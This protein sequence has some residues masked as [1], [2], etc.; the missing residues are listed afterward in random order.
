V[1][2]DVDIGELLGQ[3]APDALGSLV[4][5]HASYADCE[6][7][8]QE[9]LLAAS[10]QWPHDGIPRQPSGWLVAVASRRLIEALRRDQARQRREHRAM[11]LVPPDHLVVPGP[12]EDYTAAS[13]DTLAELF[14]CCHPA[15]SP[16]SQLALTLRVVAGMTTL[17]IA[18]AFMVPEASMAQRISRAKQRIRDEGR[19]FGLMSGGEASA[20]LRVVLHVLYLMFNEGHT[21][22][23]GPDLQRH[24]LTSEAIRLAR[25][26]H[27]FLPEDGEVLGLLALMLL[28][29]ARRLARTEA[30]GT[31]V[32]LVEQ[33]RTRWDPTAIDE[34]THLVSVALARCPVGP[35]QLQAAIAAVH[36]EA[37]QAEDTDWAQI[38]CI[39][40]LLESIEPSPVVKLSHAVAVAMVDGP[41]AG[42]DK[43]K[44]V[45]P[46]SLAAA[47]Y[48]LDAVRAHML[49]MAGDHEA[50]MVAYQAAARG[51]LS[52]S[53][54]RYL[55]HRAARL[56]N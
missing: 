44:V 10:R 34:G 32:P 11:G 55:D 39:Y 41:Q 5:H 45:D 3:L 37:T 36:A 35:Y 54:Q 33:D 31:L 38:R 46:N 6:D 20:R 16:A 21:S 27:A 52:V 26:L 24:D 2:T 18:R 17:E 48:R 53:E 50:A 15:L 43:L 13:D 19:T 29:D 25:V 23:T 47:R 4:R 14:Q 8:L 51:T 40:H 7:A 56:S 42:L 12:G 9:A 22:T 28:T 30:D 1:T 49:E